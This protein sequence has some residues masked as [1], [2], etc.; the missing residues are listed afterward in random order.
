MGMDAAL[1]VEFTGCALVQ[2]AGGVASF[3]RYCR[4]TVCVLPSA[5]SMLMAALAVVCVTLPMLTADMLGS[6][7]VVKVVVWVSPNPLASD[8]STS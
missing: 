6:N 2:L 1:V 3:S 7:F 8:T 4:C 5:L